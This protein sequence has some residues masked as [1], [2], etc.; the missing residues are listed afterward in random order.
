MKEKRL[1]IL[2]LTGLFLML[3]MGISNAQRIVIKGTILDATT[4]TALPGVNIVEQGTSNGTVTDMNGVYSIEV[5]GPSSVLEFSFVGYLSETIQTGGRTQIDVILIED[6]TK[7]DEVVVIGY[8]T[9]KKSDLTGAVSVVNT[10]DLE[11]IKSND[12]SKLLQGQTSG[13]QVFGGGEPGAMQKVQIRG[14]GTFGF[15]EPLYV[16]D[17]VPIAAATTMGGTGLVTFENN[18]S[19]FGWSAPAGGISDFNPS[20]IESIQVLKDASAAAIYGSRGANG[21]IIITTKRGKAGTA[22]L[23]YEGN[24]GVQNIAKRMDMS[25]RVQFQEVNNQARANEKQSPSEV[26]D[27]S[28]PNFIGNIDTDWEKE[29]FKQGHVTNH[30]LS[31]QGGTENATYFGNIGVFDQT[32]TIVGHGPRYTKY[33]VQLNLDQKKGRLKFGQSFSYTNSK[34]IRLTSQ[35]WTN[36]ITDFLM[37]L[38]I[39]PIYDTANIG[40]FG[41]SNTFYGQTAGN[42]IAFNSLPEVTFYRTRFLGVVYGE[43]EILKS[44]SYRINLS[45]DRSDWHNT[46]FI[47]IYFVGDKFTNATALL[48]EW[49]GETPIAIMEHLLNFKKKIGKNDIAAVIG[50]TAQKDYSQELYGHVEGFTDPGLKQISYAAATTDKPVSTL[51]VRFEHTMISYLGRVNYSYADKYLLTASI[52]RDYS[53][54]FGPLNKHGD[55]PSF[56][57]GWKISNEPFFNVPFIDLL[58][59]R[60]GYGV[61]G[62]EAI[63]AY[64]YETPINNAATYY[65]G[66][67]LQPGATQNRFRDPSIK[68]EER[69]TTDVGF[70]MAMFKN[71]V[72]ISAEYYK[73][74]ANDIL[75]PTPLPISSGVPGWAV[76][77]ANGASMT[78]SGVEISAS[79]RKYEGDLHYQIS[80]NITTLKNEVTRIGKDNAPID[81]TT[82]GSYT[83][84]GSS[85]GQNYGYVTEGIFQS[86]DEINTKKPGVTGY[87]STRHAF[88]NAKTAPGDVRFKDTNGDGIITTDDRTYLGNA[89]PKFT[90]GINL[91]ADYKGLDISVFFQGVYGNNVFNQPYRVLSAL[92]KAES[93]YT[94]E[95]YENYWK[96]DRPSDKWPR[97]TTLDNNDNNRVSDRWIQ[98]GSYLRL[99]NV[100]LGYSIPKN[101]LGRIPGIDNLR[102]Y[103]QGQNLFVITKLWG[104]DPDYINDGTYNRGYNNGS[105]PSP[106]TFLFGIKIGL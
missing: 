19:G 96:P 44:L 106:R 92:G 43:L 47:P 4:K 23:S 66:N 22:K 17:G 20:D 81:N 11:K 36:W 39:V 64:L 15:T 78:N 12:I 65:L 8:G 16:I 26:N 94:V 77:V 57:L 95:S 97:P 5:A 40:G 31:L 98:K 93:N 70:D 89:I 76:D 85:M 27:P 55:F 51:G 75:V 33:N 25:N 3:S 6:I 2:Y 30:N 91:N 53:S 29:T 59:F 7:L 21:V 42:P 41:G 86:A 83:E 9:Q 62:N 24:F 104:Y 102:I 79:Y 103:V 72:E 45:Y 58:K 88:Q 74:D 10:A 34:Q 1:F 56:A 101:I 37:A 69:I 35:R 32:S 14:I 18:A 52:R 80:G 105:F 73:N 68:W 60:G 99:Q 49:R 46:E 87:D 63:G 28:S 100:Q 61:I 67:Q 54:N 13:V 38:P 90:Y 71:K 82:T 84:V 48:S 50:Y